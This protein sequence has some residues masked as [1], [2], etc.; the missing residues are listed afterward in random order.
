MENFALHYDEDAHAHSIVMHINAWETRNA[1][2][3]AVNIIR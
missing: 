2:N 3:N 1:V